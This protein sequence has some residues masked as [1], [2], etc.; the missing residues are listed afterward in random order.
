[1]EPLKIHVEVSLSER[2]IAALTTLL[3]RAGAVVPENKP[4]GAVIPAIRPTTAPPRP[5]ADQK[6]ETA[7]NEPPVDDLPIAD[8]ELLKATREAVAR[9]KVAGGSPSLI[10]EQIFSKYGISSSTQCP[11]ESRAAL[12]RDRQNLNS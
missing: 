6:P 9:V 5:E 2:S 8:E 4:A 10:R 11:Q 3:D 7:G 12:L 1:M